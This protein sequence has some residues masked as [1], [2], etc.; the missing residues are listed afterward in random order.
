MLVSPTTL[1]IYMEH[2]IKVKISI[3]GL[4]GYIQGSM[5]SNYKMV[6]A[7][8]KFSYFNFLFWTPAIFCTNFFFLKIK[9]Q[10]VSTVLVSC[11]LL[12]RILKKNLWHWTQ[13]GNKNVKF[14]WSVNLHFKNGIKNNSNIT[15][16]K[17]IK[18]FKIIIRKGERKNLQQRNPG[19]V[20]HF[21]F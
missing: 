4:W 1:V 15:K 21:D 13:K 17:F 3:N 9:I 19:S 10:S 11:N 5:A 6:F 16:F 20:D 8:G 12:L 7:L 14:N 2:Q 18:N